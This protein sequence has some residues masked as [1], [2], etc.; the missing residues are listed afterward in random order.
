MAPRDT[1]A[2]RT[3]RPRNAASSRP[4]GQAAP[5]PAATVLVVVGTRPEVI[6]LAPV[7]RAL[8]TDPRFVVE[9][10]VVAQ[11]GELLDGALTEWGLVA[12]YRVALPGPDRRL[13]A[14]L[15]AMLP[16]LADVIGEAQPAMV[17]VEGDTTTNLA[18][19]L[20]AFYA[21]VPVAHVEAGLRSGDPQQPF[22][23]E[24]HRI[25]V[26][27]LSSV[28]YAPTI[29]ARQNLLAENLLDGDRALVVGNTVVDALMMAARDPSIVSTP[30]PSDRRVL[31]ATAHRR[32]NFGN[33][34]ESV[35]RAIRRLSTERDDLE[36]VFVLHSNPAAF[37]PVRAALGDLPNVHLIEP[38]PYRAFVKLLA[39]A[40]IVLT[41]SGGVQEEAPYLGTPVLVTR[42]LTE[43]PEASEAGAAWIVG[44]DCDAIVGAVNQLLD[45]AALYAQMSRHM[46]PYGDGRAAARIH[47]DLVRRI[48][49]RAA[50][51]PAI[52]AEPTDE[53]PLV[54]VMQA[55]LAS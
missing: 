26:D 41:D 35:C 37:G 33:G 13:A 38:Q 11:Q 15:G 2:P 20:A 44:T 52:A 40:D 19:A 1:A 23:E 22:P 28:H 49:P 32:E 47:D 54:P 7:V 4:T 10:C 9:L 43:R 17:I 25:L 29:G 14:T 27:R 55:R 53:L 34:I 18:A 48:A 50:Q 21:G 30:L 46:S 39:R 31:L 45:D 5:T 42:E 24:M 8:E 16:G 12:D 3:V 6:K 36:V 51:Q